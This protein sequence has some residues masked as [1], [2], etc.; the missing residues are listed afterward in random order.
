M[1]ISDVKKRITDTIERAR[2]A[3]AERRGRMDEASK[4]YGV[5]LDKVAVPM[6]RQ[7]ANVLRAS[8][9]PFTVMTP[10]GSVRLA[11]DRTAEDHVEIELDTS[12]DQP[13]VLG[14]VSRSRGRRILADERAVG[15]GR[16]IRDLTEQDVLDFLL[17]ALEPFVER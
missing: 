2:R 8:G 16:P 15:R 11:S 10:G 6:F 7:V 1:E 3:A 14:R 13:E 12:G 4:E 9:Y 17:K 5:F